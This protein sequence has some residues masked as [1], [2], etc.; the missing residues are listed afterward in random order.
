MS[1]SEIERKFVLAERPAG[2]ESHPSRAL[3]QGYL[4][5]GDDGVEVRVRAADG[6]HTLT[7]KSGP[8]LVRVEEEMAIDERRFRSLWEL[9]GGRRVSKRRYRIPL[10]DDL[11]AEVDVYGERLAGLLTAEIEFPSEAAS[12]AFA[13]PDWLGREVTGDA[14]Y[15]NRSLALADGPPG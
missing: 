12:A 9:T 2:L 3:D 4:A 14:R 8:G 10:G 13:P 15:A 7:I 11:V 1:G 5:V 6:D